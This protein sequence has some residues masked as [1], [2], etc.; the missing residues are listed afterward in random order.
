MKSKRY[1]RAGEP[2]LAL[3]PLDLD[4]A[5]P[6]LPAPRPWRCEMVMCLSKPGWWLSKWGVLNCLN[7]CPPSSPDLVVSQG[8]NEDAPMV[9]PGQSTIP[10]DWAPPSAERSVRRTPRA[11]K[12]VKAASFFGD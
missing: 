5:L 2:Q 6:G 4:A 12:R 10:L 9:A 11:S 3:P 8:T 7:C 1:S